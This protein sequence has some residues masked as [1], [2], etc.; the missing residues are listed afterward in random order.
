MRTM[1][2][3]LSVPIRSRFRAR[4]AEPGPVPDFTDDAAMIDHAA[5]SMVPLQK[6][7]RGVLASGEVLVSIRLR[8][9][10]M[11]RLL[12]LAAIGSVEAE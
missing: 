1:T 3:G 10:Q 12:L 9:K 5:H 8:R 4:R 11:R 2:Q 7:E 6:R